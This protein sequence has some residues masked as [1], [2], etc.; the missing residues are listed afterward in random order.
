M[1]KKKINV[2]VLLGGTSTE[3]E[4]S[5]LTGTTVINALDKN[6]Y[7]IKPVKI[8]KNGTWLVPNGYIKENSNFEFRISNFEFLNFNTGLALN[9]IKKANVDVVFIALHGKFGEDGTIQGL[10]DL[11]GIPYTGS[12]VMASALAMNKVKSME[13]F[14]FHGLK[15]PPYLVFDKIQFQD[16]LVEIINEIKTKLG[17]PCV[18]KPTDGGSSAGV[19][20]LKSEKEIKQAVRKAFEVTNKLMFQQYIKGDEV[21]CAVLDTGKAPIALPPTQ[22]IPKISDFFDYKA[23]YTPGASEEITPARF[24]QKTNKKIQEISLKAHKILECSGLSRADMIVS[25]DDIYILETN[26]IPG[27]TQISLYPQAA[28]KIGLSFEVLLDKMIECALK[29]L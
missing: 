11:A 17:F 16:N 23:K 28:E 24:P 9:S 26:T 8:E 27:M 5:L 12:G 15:V 3:H 21:T 6:K 4:I 2:A 19:Y 29:K 1:S 18:L 22:I 13:I 10:L 7:N 20:I 25:D 14:K